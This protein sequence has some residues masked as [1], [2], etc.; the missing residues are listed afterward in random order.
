MA[1]ISAGKVSG[2]GGDTFAALKSR[3]AQGK[4]KISPVATKSRN[5]KTAWNK[6]GKK[7]FAV[8]K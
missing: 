3:L 7:T 8:K 6:T 4:G 1:M 2:T 5:A